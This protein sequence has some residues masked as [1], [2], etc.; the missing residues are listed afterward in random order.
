MVT[1]RIKGWT[2]DVNCYKLLWSLITLS[3]NHQRAASLL[4]SHLSPIVEYQKI[5]RQNFVA[6]KEMSSTLYV[7]LSSYVYIIFRSNVCLIMI[8]L[9][10]PHMS[11]FIHNAESWHTFYKPCF[12]VY[13]A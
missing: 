7:V 11:E 6:Q 10:K 1:K 2:E 9:N 8:F 4:L 12:L 3:D 5:M 13:I